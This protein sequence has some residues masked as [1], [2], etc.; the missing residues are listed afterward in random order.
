MKV[1]L[2]ADIHANLPALE[3]VLAHARKRKVQAIWNAGDFVGYGPF[4]DEVVRRVRAE[5][6]LSIAGNYDLKVLKAGR[7]PRGKDKDPEKR[8]AFKW[9]LDNLSPESREYLASL[10]GELRLNIAGRRVLLTHGSPESNKERLTPE[11]PKSRLRRLARKAK[12]D[13]IVCGHSHVP[14]ARK[15][16]AHWF[17][18]PG[19]IGRPDDGNPQ[20]SYAVIVLRRVAG[21]SR[22]GSLAVRHYRVPY[23]AVRTAERI[24]QLGLPESFARMV[25]EGRSLDGVQRWAEA[26]AVTRASAPAEGEADAPLQ[27]VLQLAEKCDHEP[28]H[29]RHVTLLALRLFDELQ[30]LHGLGAMERFW[31]HCAGLLHDLGWIEGRKGHHKTALRMIL[32]TPDLPFERREREII[33]CVARYHRRG[34]PTPRHE[35]FAALSAPDQR[36][37]RRLA[38]ILRVADGLDRTHQGIVKD[39]TCAIGKKQVSV[40]CLVP[41]PAEEE[42]REALK[43]GD[44]FEKTFDRKL[45]IGWRLT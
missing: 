44:L 34:L 17:I 19:S 9:A 32:T 8:Y 11:T 39:V 22:P 27:A 33:G 18:N 5:K 40:N 45:M 7:P 41:Q 31:L 24:R 13:L 28:A 37:V 2:I 12:A 43:K 10:P 35:T 25:L 16:G 30:P 4:P 38:A 26:R 14:F 36:V 6:A 42:Q 20:A 1:A 21:E 29:T 15:V 3:A 23:D